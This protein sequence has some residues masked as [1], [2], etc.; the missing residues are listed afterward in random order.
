MQATA[1]GKRMAVAKNRTAT[2][3]YIGD[4]AFGNREFTPRRLALDDWYSGVT[5]WTN[6]S[7]AVLFH[8]KRNG[9]WAIF[10]QNIDAKM[11]ET[12]I[13]GSENYLFPKL[14]SQGQ[15]LYTATAS[16]DRWE[17]GDTTIRLMSTPEQGGARSTL[18]MG[19][20]D[21][22][23]G[24]SPSSS[25]VVSELEDRQ[26]IFF[27]LDPVKGR[28]EE[29]GRISGYQGYQPDWDLSPDGLRLAIVDSAQFSGD[30]RIMDAAD[31]SVTVLPVRNWKWQFLRIVR[32]AADGKSLFALATSGS[33]VALISIDANGNPRV[34]HEIP[35]GAGWIGSI[36]PS[37]DGKRLAFTQR[38][39]VDDIMLLEKF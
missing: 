18:M 33:S 13:G 24:S 30:I 26:L 4:L 19:R 28:G 11:P 10:K 36:V 6:D 38:V 7:K 32:W 5:A 22:A 34:M 1:D 20:Y 8:S 35:I 25:C 29:I 14:S 27:H 2:M 37:P 39:Y 9:R 17:P 23:C 31:R 16:Q 21:Y 15:L 12:L 3:T